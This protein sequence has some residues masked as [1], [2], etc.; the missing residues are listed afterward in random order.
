M[1]FFFLLSGLFLGWSL[2]ANDAANVYGTAVG[3]RMVKFR[4]AAILCSVFVVIGAVVG[5]A[6]PSETLGELGAVNA[7][8]GAFTVALSAGLTVTGMTRLGLPVSTSQAIVGGIIGWNLFAG[9]PTDVTS[10]TKIV[11]SWVACPVLAAA[12]AAVL[13]K[14]AQLAMYGLKM[15]LFRIDAVTRWGLVI[16]GAFAAYSL[17][18]NNI[19]NVM[20]VFVPAAPFGEMNVLGRFVLSPAQQ[21]FFIGGLA[22]AVG[23]FT[24]SKSVM[25]TVGNDLFRMTP[26]AALIV[27]LAQALV[28]FL[29]SS[30]GLEHWLSTHGLPTIPL[31]PVSS[32]QAV[33]G[34]VIGLGL[35]KGGRNIRLG[36]L[37]QVVGGWVAT[38]LLAGGLAF[39]LLFFVQNV[40]SQQVYS[41]AIHEAAPVVAEEVPVEAEK[42][43]VQEN[44][45]GEA[46]D[47][48]E[49]APAPT[50]AGGTGASAGSSGK[51]SASGTERAAGTGTTGS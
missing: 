26:I 47:S 17:G 29:F 27:V 21:L 24:Y 8:A 12:F 31:V 15:H 50:S 40:F 46:T 44:A 9:S 45:A 6:G 32:S 37:G 7:L 23:V 13:L 33:I 39:V 19:A 30:K 41:A 36:T 34:A 5:G 1:F 3:T 25:L 38:P 2:G 48:G 14:L 42:V 10:L 43:S 51:G 49:A 35:A 11:T 22:I 20:G 18:A 16:V 4:T 28:L